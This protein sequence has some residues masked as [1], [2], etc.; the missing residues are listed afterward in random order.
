MAEFVEGPD[1]DENEKAALKRLAEQGLISPEPGEMAEASENL[2]EFSK[3]QLND[4]DRQ[5]NIARR[6]LALE[7]ASGLGHLFQ[8]PEDF[9]KFTDDV[10][11]YLS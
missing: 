11:R 3:D 6:T 1:T 7:V 10:E 5:V 4:H 2:V 8:S 9:W